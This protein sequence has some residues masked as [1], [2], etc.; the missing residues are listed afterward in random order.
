MA[1]V[2]ANYEFLF[3][4]V[5]TNGRISD[6]GVIQNTQFCEKLV[7]N[8][9]NLPPAVNIPVDPGNRSLFNC[10]SIAQEA[11]VMRTD[12]LKPYDQR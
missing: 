4:D 3:A 1:M 9:L 5:G 2:N 11:F 12:L 7:S 6:G 8:E 10:V